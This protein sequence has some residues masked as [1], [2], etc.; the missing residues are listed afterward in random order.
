MSLLPHRKLSGQSPRQHERGRSLPKIL[1]IAVS[2]SLQAGGASGQSHLLPL[3]V[4]N[5][6]T[7]E[8]TVY[9]IA[10]DYYSG[11]VELTIEVLSKSAV[12]GHD[13]FRLSSPPYDVPAMPRYF[14]SGALLRWRDDGSLAL[15]SASGATTILQFSVLP[16]SYIHRE[17]GALIKAEEWS[18][19]SRYPRPRTGFGINVDGMLRGGSSHISFSP[20]YGFAHA[21]QARF[22]T[23]YVSYDNQLTPVRAIIAGRSISY[24]HVT[25]VAAASWAAV[26]VDTRRA[27]IHQPPNLAGRN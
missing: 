5:S 18:P 10:T 14:P 7:F 16:H 25:A 11:V 3:A 23:D 22:S 1:A 20:N 2:I 6:W 9:D 21:G 26:K 24:A 13:Y 4:G 15:L 12:D 17:T 27:P 19:T 8:H